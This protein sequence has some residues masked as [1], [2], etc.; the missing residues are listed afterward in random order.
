MVRQ[1]QAQHQG[2]AAQMPQRRQVEGIK[3]SCCV[4]AYK[5]AYAPAKECTESVENRGQLRSAKHLILGIESS[6]AIPVSNVGSRYAAARTQCVVECAA[7]ISKAESDIEKLFMLSRSSLRH[8]R[9]HGRAGHSH[10]G[11]AAY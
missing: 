10:Q 1:R 9:D 4:S 5:V 6:T 3:A 11:W 2:C 8:A 7:A